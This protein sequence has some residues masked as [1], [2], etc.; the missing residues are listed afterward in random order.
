MLVNI[1]AVASSELLEYFT[2]LLAMHLF[3]VASLV[4]L[5]TNLLLQSFLDLARHISLFLHEHGHAIHVILLLI[6]L[7]LVKTALLLL[8]VV[9][10]LSR[11]LL[12]YFLFGLFQALI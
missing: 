12:L 8:L 6:E 11:L 4:Y 1:I 2:L 3:L 7:E 5:G 9:V 10:I